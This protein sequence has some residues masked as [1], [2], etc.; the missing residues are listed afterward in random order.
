[1]ITSKMGTLSL[2]NN[3]I[4]TNLLLIVCKLLVML[5]ALFIVAHLVPGINNYLL[6]QDIQISKDAVPYSLYLN[7]DSFF[8]GLV[9]LYFNFQIKS[10]SNYEIKRSIKIGVIFGI[11]SVVIL[12]IVSLILGFIRW[13]FKL[14]YIALIF[15]FQNL[16]FTCFYEEV[17]WRGFIQKN[18]VQYTNALTGIILTAL[19]FAVAHI[20]FA[21]INFAILAFIAA[22]LYGSCYYFS[23][24]KIESSIVCH[25]LVNIT[26]FI[27][28]TYPILETAL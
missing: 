6:F 22:I 23:K 24:N 4:R 16:I 1:M 14:T 28:F 12:I 19:L 8:A 9:I 25:Y 21:G 11:T 13:D 18:L 26:H 17:I 5:G 2:G 15:V 10:H 20:Q 27:F 7:Y 3:K